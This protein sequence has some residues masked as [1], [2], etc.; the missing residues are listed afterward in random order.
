MASVEPEPAELSVL[1]RRS[2]SGSAARSVLGGYVEWPS[3]PGDAASPAGQIATPDHWELRDVIVV[4]SSEAK[5]VSS[6]E[7]HLRAPSSPHFERRQELLPERLEVMRQALAARDLERLGEAI[8]TEAIEL[9]LVAMSSLPPIFYWRPGTL[10]VLARV[11]AL[12]GEGIGVWA[13]MDAGPNVHLIC[14][15]GDESGVVEAMRELAVVESLIRDRVGGG[16]RVS[17]EH[18]F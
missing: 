6:R 4:V 18:L 13:T 14:E 17:D 10:E 8:E 3:V 15:P 12:R 1:A 5:R 2:G 16:P 7:G 11:R 9:H